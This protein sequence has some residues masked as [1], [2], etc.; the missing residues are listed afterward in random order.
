MAYVT[1][2]TVWMSKVVKDWL[3]SAFFTKNSRK[4]LRNM[5]DANVRSFL[6]CENVRSVCK[7]AQSGWYM[8]SESMFHDWNGASQAV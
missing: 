8:Q 3:T 2:P 5:H 6:L 4:V 1:I 7:S